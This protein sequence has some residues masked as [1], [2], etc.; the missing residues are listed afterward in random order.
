LHNTAI[1]AVAYGLASVLGLFAVGLIA[2]SYGLAALGLIVLVRS[3][4]PAGFLALL[5]FGISEIATQAVARGRVTDWNVA[6]EQVA[7][8]ALLGSVIGLGSGM[9]LW[10]AAL[11]LASLF[12]VAPDQ[13]HAFVS[14]M[15]ATAFVLP[16]AF[17]GIVGEGVLKGFEEYGWLR[18]T[19][20]IG[21]AVYVASV[22][23]AVWSGAP[24]QVVAYSFLAVLVIKYVVLAFV[25]CIVVRK[26]PLRPRGWSSE[27]QRY[28]LHRCWLMFHNRIAGT[29]QQT[30]VPLVIGAMYNPIEVGAYDLIT[31]LPRFLKAT[32][33]PL[34][35][36][37]LPMST[38]IEELADTRR[39]QILGRNGLV[40][41]AAIVIP[42]LVV[43]GLFSE[44]ILSVWVGPQHADQWPWLAL[45]LLVPAVNV[46][47]GAGQTALMLRSDFLR[48]NTRYQYLQV[49]VQYVITA[50]TIFWFRE[51]A[52][53]LGWV[54][55][56]VLFAPLIAR[57]MLSF[58]GLPSSLFWEQVGRQAV[59]ALIL[60]I[61]FAI[62][63]MHWSPH[64]LLGLMIVGAV[65]C[66]AAWV[67]SA[68]LILSPGD[69]AMFGLFARTMK[70]RT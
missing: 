55:S 33:A 18:L 57:R 61:I 64:G 46:M 3:F 47:L 6:S 51:H 9:V 11:P 22:F 66:I 41:P 36:A 27:S 62:Y 52:F 19:E 48:L 67:L 40:L 13:I 31:R 7:L 4:L 15:E 14:M 56:Y 63:K 44:D 28:V 37:V 43:V 24:I 10:F 8:L 68:T 20:I 50:S 17:L 70:P 16:I 65:G 25:I 42:L 29:F 53:I 58:M 45:S 49:V 32:I 59:V 60:T 39:L 5:D 2:R 54:I 38:R 69:R 26:V 1:S 30:L 35:A 21:N 23:L 12:K 34:Y